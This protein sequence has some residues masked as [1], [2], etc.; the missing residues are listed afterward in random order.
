MQ[1][2][3]GLGLP[4]YNH[5]MTR[6]TTS[7]P[8]PEPYDSGWLDTED[9]HRLWYVQ[10][11][12]PAGLP[13]L[14]LHGGPGSGTSLRHRE[15]IDLDRYRL[16]MYDQ[17]GCGCS[18]PRGTL[19]GND[20]A[21]LL[22]DL[23]LLS[24]RLCLDRP[25]LGGGSWGATLALA[26]A[27]AHRWQVSALLLRAPFLASRQEIDAFFTPLSGTDDG[28]IEFAS[29]AMP[30]KR[31]TGARGLLKEYATLL[32]G[33]DAAALAAACAWYGHQQH[34]EGSGASS[35]TLLP[36]A[37]EL[38]ARYRI[39]AHYLRHGCF[40]AP[41]WLGRLQGRGYDLPV[42]ILHGQQD[43]ICPFANALTLQRLLPGSRVCLVAGSG[44]DPFHPGM[45][46]ALRAALDCYARDGD[47][48][49][50]GKG[51]SDSV[52]EDEAP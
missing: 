13:L 18:V 30:E 25:I 40:L 2:V 39:Q 17:R 9:G 35:A 12:N 4:V 6:L 45:A 10:F 5:H 31:A 48:R 22:R 11:G 29:Q 7:S 37:D 19:C 42:A 8:L 49:A 23:L 38:L 33:E 43:R 44:H 27:A 28:W 46:S 51:E 1:G 47:F 14:W 32:A 50:W 26:F 16:V 21:A 3:L 34:R 41:D 24:T 36:P 20:T 15:L 52:N